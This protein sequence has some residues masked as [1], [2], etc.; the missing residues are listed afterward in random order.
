M[1]PATWE[2]HIICMIYCTYI[3]WD[4]FPGFRSVLH[5]RPRTAPD[6]GRLGS[7]MI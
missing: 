3:Q 7:E 5:S 1:L 6:D 4:R 2:P